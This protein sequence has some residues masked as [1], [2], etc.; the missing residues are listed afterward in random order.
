GQM[1]Q[2]I[3]ERAIG[4]ARFEEAP[5]QFLVPSQAIVCAQAFT[6]QQGGAITGVVAVA[7]KMRVLIIQAQ[8]PL[9]EPV[10]PISINAGQ[11]TIAQLVLGQQTELFRLDADQPMVRPI[12]SCG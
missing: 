4:D 3:T 11:L 5:L 10:M 12:S 6:E 8:L 2:L 7:I 9:V 1:I